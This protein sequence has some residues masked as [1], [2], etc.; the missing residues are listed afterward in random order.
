MAN[1]CYRNTPLHSHLKIKFITL[2]LILWMQ[3]LSI[4]NSMPVSK[5]LKCIHVEIQIMQRLRKNNPLCF[6]KFTMKYPL[7]DYRKIC[8][9]HVPKF[10]WK[11]QFFFLQ[12]TEFAEKIETSSNIKFSFKICSHCRKFKLKST[13]KQRNKKKQNNKLKKRNKKFE[14]NFN[15]TAN[16][17]ISKLRIDLF[18][19]EPN[20]AR[21]KEQIWRR[22]F[23]PVST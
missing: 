19:N 2:L 9:Y 14:K 21:D 7:F 8:N 20:P 12:F 17:A 10:T 18:R 23:H 13:D 4:R 3:N 16:D 11:Y 22:A 1:N 15:L 6:G 5:C